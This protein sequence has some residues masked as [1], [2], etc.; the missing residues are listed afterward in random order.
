[1]TKK[2]GPTLADIGERQ[3]IEQVVVSLARKCGQKN[4]PGDDCAFIDVG[5]MLFAVTADVGPKPLVRSLQPYKDDFEA[6]GWHAAV[7]TV[8]DVATAGATP[9]LLTNCVDA[10]ADS[11]VEAL[12]KF[13][14][15][16]FRACAHFGFQNAGG[17]MRQGSVL[18]ATVFGVGLV[19]HGCRIGR[20]GARPGDRLVLI[21]NAGRFM[22]TYLIALSRGVVLDKEQAN[23]LRFP[24]PP[25]REMKSLAER[26]FVAAASDTSDGLLGAI[27]N[28]ARASDCSFMLSLDQR[29]LSPTIVEAAKLH[30]YDPWNIFFC[31]GDWSIAAIVPERVYD[32]FAAYARDRQMSWASLG[33]VIA[34]D[35]HLYV[36]GSKGI[37]EVMPVRNEN[38]LPAG[39]NAGLSG[40]LAYM[41]KTPILV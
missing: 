16:Y 3:I 38:F 27:Q 20:S 28:I 24:E 37:S 23:V 32:R 39:F 35:G 29:L 31:W 1:M 19:E 33:Y 8:S 17:D 25:L 5:S 4:V 9:V 6:G 22:A 2:M 11:P 36:D 18:E 15:G 40:H 41:L 21:G 7:A 14:D 10:P 26:G 13:M 34:G 12:S 30:D